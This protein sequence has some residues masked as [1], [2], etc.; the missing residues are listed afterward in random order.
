VTS[1]IVFDFDGTVI[2]GNGPV[3]AYAREMARFAPEGFLARAEA[4]IA[5]FE[6]GRAASYRDGYDV[7][8]TLGTDAGVSAGDRQLAYLASRE[9]L[10]SAQPADPAPGLADILARIPEETRVVLA[11]NAPEAGV[12]S[13]LAGWGIRDRFD[14]LIYNTG[15][16]AGLGPIVDR[17][18]LD[19]PVLSVG[20]I[21]I[22]DLDPATERGADTA[23]VGA[24]AETSTASVTM[25][26]TTLAELADQIVAWAH[27]AEFP[28]APPP[29]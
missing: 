25:R 12:E 18:L 20:D 11:T 17:A 19:G 7:V 16:P 24:T 1:T 2:V 21:V 13:A 5:A 10:G 22:N 27:A 29:V 15:K 9:L 14:E 28:T 3:L 6:A 8:G 26:A 4:E 23:L